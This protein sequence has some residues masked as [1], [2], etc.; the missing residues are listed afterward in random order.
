MIERIKRLLHQAKSE[1]RN[2]TNFSCVIARSAFQRRSNPE[3]QV[4]N[5][6]KTRAQV[7]LE[8]TFSM[9][10]VLL[11]MYGV[12]RVMGWLSLTLAERRVAHDHSLIKR[13]DVE[14]WKDIYKDPSPLLQL[15][16][17]F[18]TTNKLRL[19]FNGW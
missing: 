13:T 16:P 5:D 6:T 2:D 18:Y 15:Q 1:V 17:E 10:L 11:L 3:K 8:F 7:T 14:N 12:I 9:I 19:V 4:R